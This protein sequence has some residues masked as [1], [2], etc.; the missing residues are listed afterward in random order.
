MIKQPEAP[1]FSKLDRNKIFNLFQII[2]F[3]TFRSCLAAMESADVAQ[4]A[5]AE[6]VARDVGC[7]LTSRPP[8]TPPYDD[9]S[10]GSFVAEGA[11]G[12]KCGGNCK[13]DPCNC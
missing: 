9:G 8:P 10:E 13:C 2:N 1:S 6:A 12:C 3:K 11:Q 5:L 4:A 7:I